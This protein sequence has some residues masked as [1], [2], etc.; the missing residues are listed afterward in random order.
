VLA[1]LERELKDEAFVV[2]GVHS[3]KFPNEQDAEMV[4]QAVMRY[5]VTH[6]VI[7]DP[8]RDIWDEWG[9]NA[10]P[11]LAIVSADGQLVA[12]GAGEPDIGVLREAVQALLELARNEGTLD[13]KP[14]PLR[15]EPV[16][17]GSLAYPG[18]V[19]VAGD[20]LWVADTGHNQVVEF[21][22]EGEELGRHEGFH[23]P[24][25]LAFV[26][27]TL[28]VAD[29]G[30]GAVQTLDGRV[31][32]ES[33]RSPWDLVW[34]GELLYIAMA[35]SHQI[36]FHD[37]AT[38]E[39]DVFAGTGRELRVD[40]PIA[41]AAFAQPS[42]LAFLDDS[43]YIADS[44][45]SS[46]RAIDG[47]RAFPKARTVCGSGELFGFGDRDGIGDEVRLQHPIGVAAGNGEL[48]VAD[49]FNHKVKRVDPQ[50]GECRT[51]FGRLEQLPVTAQPGFWEPEGLAYHDGRLYVADT[52]NHRIVALD[53][54]SGERRTLVGA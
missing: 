27:E 45:I 14:L 46:I 13:P 10:W 6:P 31:V 35:G 44:E 15:P 52:N 37:P 42:G 33:L 11:T 28:Y 48:W 23:H 47:L 2:I 32:A 30:A 5:G 51:A 49:S 18:K 8:G 7:V 38:E 24:N 41:Q 29:T 21:S 25:G 1:A 12:A 50:T 36:W 26:R 34:D 43:L 17:A 4:R 54:E 53:V 22:L 39:T 16:Q 9:V 19:I 20:R 40:G 3:P